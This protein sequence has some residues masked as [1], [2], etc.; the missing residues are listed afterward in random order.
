MLKRSGNTILGNSRRQRMDLER[1][2]EVGLAALAFLTEEPQRLTRFVSMSGLTPAEL[3]AQAA[4]PLMQAAML[5]HLLADETLLLVFSADKRI[6]PE[7]VGPACRLL[8]G[9]HESDP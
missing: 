2:E 8:A 6:E 1:A 7:D 4:E 5:E 9:S 3:G